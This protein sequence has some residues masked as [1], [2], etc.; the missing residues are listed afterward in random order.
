MNFDRNLGDIEQ[1]HGMVMNH[2]D[3]IL[4]LGEKLIFFI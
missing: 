4:E 3:Q 2:M 1:N